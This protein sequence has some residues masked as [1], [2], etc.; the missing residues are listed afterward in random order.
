[1]L[2]SGAQP[3][4]ISNSHSALRQDIFTATGARDA[5]DSKGQFEIPSRLC[6]F[7]TFTVKCFGRVLTADRFPLK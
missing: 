2:A 7:A 6:G 5:K 1:M 4:A 3:P